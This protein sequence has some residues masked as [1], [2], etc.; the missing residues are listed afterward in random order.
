MT[1]I[2]KETILEMYK[3]MNQARAFE[4]KVSY[5]FA[6]GMVHGTTHLSV[7]E[8][9][10]SV[11][12]CMALNKDDLITSTHRGHSQVIGKGIDLNKMM[13]ELLGK[14]T[15]YCKGKG[16]SMHIADVEAGNLGA[17]GVVGGGHGIAVGAALTQQMKKTGKIVLCFFGDGASNEGSFHESL[18][19]ASVW[20]L[21][22]IF[23]C[24]NNLYGM[25]VPVKNSMNIKDIAIRAKAYGIPG[26][27]VDGNN[28]IDVYNLIKEVSEYVR[29]G[30]GPVLVESKTY[31]WLGHSKS[32]AQV[33]RT[34]EE[35][36]EWKK[37]CPIRRLRKYILENNIAKEEELNDIEKTAK[38][39][40]EEAVEFA[41]NSPNPPI[42]TVTE[43]VYA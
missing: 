43:D 26:Y 22:V 19:L 21:P 2:D 35:V 41:N 13:A 12:A 38:D 24:E 28:A 32:D 18:N 1:Y 14:Y 9:A 20:K 33:Y 4:E 23:Y 30:K 11:A 39:Q 31:R 7:G 36:E 25:S 40:I 16:G 42:E 15:G 8:E 17:N 6:R 34:K 10:S 27:V 29:S 37:K 5:F 3:R